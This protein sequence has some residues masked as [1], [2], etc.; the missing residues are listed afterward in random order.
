MN[1][2]DDIIGL[3][4]MRFV[5]TA[6]YNFL[7]HFHCDPATGNAHNLDQLRCGAGLI[8]FLRIAI[9]D[10]IHA[11]RLMRHDLSGQSLLKKFYWLVNTAT[12]S[13]KL[14]NKEK[15]DAENII[16]ASKIPNWH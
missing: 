6:R 2:L 14:D 1:D 13:E 12:D 5:S 16:S 8:D 11:A 4:L 10:N 15:T 9:N 3:N 7:V